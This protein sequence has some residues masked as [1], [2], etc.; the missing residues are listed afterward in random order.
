MDEQKPAEEQKP[1]Y[2]APTSTP[3]VVNGRPC[4][5]VEL[6]VTK[7]KV[8]LAEYFSRGENDDHR[9]KL[10]DAAVLNGQGELTRFDASKKVLADAFQFA[11]AV[12]KITAPD[13]QNVQYSDK[14]RRDLPEEDARLIDDYITNVILKKKA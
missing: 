6:P 2:E 9:T 8:A 3:E 4:Q 1:A 11:N 10:A 7:A 14:W 13:G 5:V 12:R